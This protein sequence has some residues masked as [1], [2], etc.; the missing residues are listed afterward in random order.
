[1]TFADLYAGLP[2]SREMKPVDM[3]LLREWMIGL[4]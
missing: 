4:E 2:T 3:R 1:M